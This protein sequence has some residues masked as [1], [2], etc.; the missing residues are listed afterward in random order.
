MNMKIDIQHKEIR[1]STKILFK[2]EKN[3][4]LL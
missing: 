2:V 1:Y 4:I 3:I